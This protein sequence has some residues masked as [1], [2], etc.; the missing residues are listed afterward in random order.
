[1]PWIFM[2]VSGIVT[3]AKLNSPPEVSKYS[4]LVAQRAQFSKYFLCWEYWLTGEAYVVR[5]ICSLGKRLQNLNLP[6]H[7]LKDLTVNLMFC[8][9]FFFLIKPLLPGSLTN[10]FSLICSLCEQYWRCKGKHAYWPCLFLSDD[11][12]FKMF[13]CSYPNKKVWC[14]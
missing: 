5:S 7:F 11:V 14:L 13:S 9:L 3:C 8:P 12:W 4:A 10:L 2:Y 1:M 6:F